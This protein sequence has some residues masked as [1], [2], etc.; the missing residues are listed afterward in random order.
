MNNEIKLP[1]SIGERINF[2]GKQYVIEGVH[3]YILVNMAFYP[4]AFM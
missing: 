4:I 1:Y 3:I 2:E